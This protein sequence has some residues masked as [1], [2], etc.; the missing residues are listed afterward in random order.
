M[1]QAISQMT[2]TVSLTC[3][4]PGGTTGVGGIP[5][6]RA[7]SSSGAGHATA[8]YIPHSIRGQGSLSVPKKPERSLG[9]PASLAGHPET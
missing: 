1:A 2:E 4:E 5:A 7:A 3:S 8:A 6:P 9:L